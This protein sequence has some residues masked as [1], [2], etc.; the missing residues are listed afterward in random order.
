MNAG[1]HRRMDADALVAALV[2]HGTAP[3]VA[4]AVPFWVDAARARGA[5]HE[6]WARLYREVLT[7]AHDFALHLSLYRRCYGLDDSAPL[8]GPAWLPTPDVIAR[9]N[10]TAA[11]RD[12]G[13]ADYPALHRWSVEDRGR[14]WQYVVERLGIRF[15]Q[16]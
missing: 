6:A 10:V 15:R 9:A 4:R 7:P 2:A 3:D 8:D 14:Y 16:P 11:A 5:P 13:L 12:L 1:G